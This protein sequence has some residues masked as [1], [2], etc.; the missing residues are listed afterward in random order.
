MYEFLA[1]FLDAADCI[2]STENIN[3]YTSP[4]FAPGCDILEISGT[5]SSGKNFCLRV[6]IQS[7]DNVLKQEKNKNG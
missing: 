6:E 1:T 5:A 3:M 7:T 2:G 4:D